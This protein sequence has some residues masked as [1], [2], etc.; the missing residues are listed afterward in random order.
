MTEVCRDWP[1]PMA[2]HVMMLWWLQH[3]VGNLT[4]PAAVMFASATYR[5]PR[6]H[7]GHPLPQ[8]H[9]YQLR[10]FTATALPSCFLCPK[11]K[12][13]SNLPHGA[14]GKCLP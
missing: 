7:T 1:H 5:W 12:A 4:L 11:K 10:A 6:L 3:P 9:K 8:K 2:L 13:L 14:Y